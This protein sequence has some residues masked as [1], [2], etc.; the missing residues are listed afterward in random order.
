VGYNACHGVYGGT[1]VMKRHKTKRHTNVRVPW[2]LFSVPF[3]FFA[4][5]IWGKEREAMK[6]STRVPNRSLYETRGVGS[7]PERTGGTA[8]CQTSE[9]RYGQQGGSIRVGAAGAAWLTA[10][11]AGAVQGG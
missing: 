4:F 5:S 2:Q 3:F 9:G 10:R 1:E 7:A 11:Q 6:L 8:A